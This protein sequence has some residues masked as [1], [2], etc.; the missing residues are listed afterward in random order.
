MLHRFMN[1][2]RS[3]ARC[4]WMGSSESPSGA[5]AGERNAHGCHYSWRARGDGGS[6]AAARGRLA[7]RAARNPQRRRGKC[8]WATTPVATESN[9]ANA[10]PAT[11]N[12][13]IPV[14]IILLRVTEE[15][16][17]VTENS[18]QVD[19]TRS[20]ANPGRE[21]L[22]LERASRNHVYYFANTESVSLL[23]G[24]S[25]PA[26]CFIPGNPLRICVVV[27]SNT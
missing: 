9:A 14:L 23:S 7:A 2:E 21:P 22:W 4:E 10:Q 3:S 15:R 13:E 5:A 17:S 19:S 24:F 16:L 26:P 18:C 27:Q 25:I 8:G 6:A 12:W 20:A 1:A 11:S